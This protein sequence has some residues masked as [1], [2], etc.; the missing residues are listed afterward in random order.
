MYY[1]EEQTKLN[2]RE[3]YKIF[4][5]LGHYLK[6][7]R[8]GLLVA[9]L[10]LFI[11][12]VLALAGPYI[13]K[14]A[15]DEYI[16]TANVA[17]LTKM[18]VL[19]LAV[20]LLIGVI[21]YI[22]KYLVMFIGQRMMQNLAVD[23][24]SKFQNLSLSFYNKNAVGKLITRV[25]NDIQ[26]LQELFTSGVVEGLGD[27]LTLIGIIVLMFYLNFKLTLIT[28][29]ILP[30]MVLGILFFRSAIRKIYGEIRVKIA[31]INSFLNE[32]I[33]GMKVVQLFS[34]ERESAKEFDTL[35]E[36][37]KYLW[38]KTIIHF[39]IF[40][41]FVHFMGSFFTAAILWFG[42]GQVIRGLVTFGELVAFLQYAQRFFEPLRRLSDKYNIFLSAVAAA[43]KVFGVL[44]NKEVLQVTEKPISIS[45]VEQ[46]L[47]FDNVTF[48]YDSDE[49]V[50]KNIS[51]NIKSGEKVAI[52]GATGAGKTTIINLLFRFYD[53]NQGR[54]L[55]G[56]RNLCEF[57]LK[58]LRR[59][60]GLVQQ[61]VFLFSGTIIDNIRLG[62]EEISEADVVEAAKLVNADTFIRKLPQ[63]YYTVLGERGVGLSTGEKQLL[64]FA[65][66][67][68]LKPRILL[69][70]DEATSN[71]D[72]ES[73][74]LIQEGLEHLLES[75]T[76]LVIAHRLSTIKKVDRIIV[77]H[78]G[79]LREEGTHQELMEK[80]GL[81][82]N[83]Y[84]FQFQMAN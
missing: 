65:R 72:S 79:E 75:R 19:Y 38:I 78:K 57:D 3:D 81:Y 47:T 52:V 15:I 83:L 26:S 24:F 56:G 8:G 44:D 69:I 60:F 46:E 31:Q 9:L 28:L 43:Q 16:E 42:G 10:L 64:A 30:I 49:P 55:I 51:F 5:R 35:T 54:I 62:N 41:P 59:N 37:H 80:E 67:V 4:F 82:Y 13:T 36:Q 21:E 77:L 23:T 29:L 7:Y 22:R 33:V 20:V 11:D 74:K 17:G 53:I 25:T 63:G 39:G 1:E 2:L 84:H 66:T 68:V 14:I 58:D 61:E 70:M 48:S 50:L 12:M 40:M 32:H 76:A 6:P 71:I 18:S 73:E 27:I 45:S 34:M